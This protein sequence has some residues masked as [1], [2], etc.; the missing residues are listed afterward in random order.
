VLFNLINNWLE[1]EKSLG[2]A[3]P[4]RM[5]LATAGKDAIPHCRIV[6][7]KEILNHSIIFFTQK[8][9]RKVKEMNENPSVSATIWL[10]L[11]Q[12]EVILDGEVEALTHDE[13]IHYWEKMLPDNRLRFFTYAPVSGMPISSLRE[14][15]DRYE[16]L[17]NQINGS[18]VPMSDFYVGYRLKPKTIVLYTLGTDTFSE[19]YRYQLINGEWSKQ[20]ISA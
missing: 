8:E 15:E 2:S 16:L 17:K 5:V 9:T 6:A 7:I 1:N 18:D 13:N 19:V 20:L 12:R 4:N 3:Y 14:L 11:Q 10:P